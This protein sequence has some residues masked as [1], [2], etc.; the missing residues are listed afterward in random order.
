M[1]VNVVFSWPT[2]GWLRILLA[3]MVVDLHYGY[4]AYLYDMLSRKMHLHAALQFCGDGNIAVVGFF[5]MS[6]FLVAEILEHKYPSHS[7]ADFL[8]FTT[9][10]YFRIFP[11]YWL[12]FAVT[13]LI[14]WAILPV[15]VTAASVVADG[16]LLPYGLY[17]FFAARHWFD[18][19]LIVPAWSLSL[20]LVFY[21]IGYLFYKDR[22]FLHAGIVLLMGYLILVAIFAQQSNA[23][24]APAGQFSTHSWWHDE[25]YMTI[26][27]NLLAYFMGMFARSSGKFVLPAWALPVSVGVI[28]YVCYLPFGLSPFAQEGVAL[29]AFVALIMRLAQ[30]GRAK[31]E[32]LMSSFTYALYLVHWPVKIVL[33]HYFN[34]YANFVTRSVPLLISL[35]LAGWLAMYV[36]E[37][38]VE[39]ARRRWLASWKPI[40]DGRIYDAKWL[41]YGSFALMASSVL[42]Y[43]YRFGLW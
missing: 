18:G 9:S 10:R 31:K 21:P 38:I 15:S 39:P 2:L 29:L 12:V 20:D 1:K 24:V 40:D 36:E 13:G 11:L 28:L 7:V 16:S 8:H 5:V 32:S 37:G 17:D 6:G 41:Q 34:F 27:P 42:F 43:G 23:F 35:V 19:M 3:G 25:F 4:F 14:A 33:L 22:R 30:N 26:L